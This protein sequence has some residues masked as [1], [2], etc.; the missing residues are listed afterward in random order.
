MLDLVLCEIEPPEG[1]RRGLQTTVVDRTQLVAIAPP[2]VQP[3]ADWKNVGFAHY[4]PSSAYRW[5]V[6]TFLDAH[7]LQPRIVAE[8][9]D[10]LFLVEVSVRSPC[11]AIVPRSAAKEALL[12]GRVRVIAELESGGVAVHALYQDNIAAGLTR[13]A[14]E[15][16][17]RA[18]SEPAAVV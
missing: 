6:S 2:A 11:V 18:H 15:I 16:L 1:M 9:D 7:G 10:S 14:V 8:S 4:R 17:V 13:S 12:D 3:A 5:E